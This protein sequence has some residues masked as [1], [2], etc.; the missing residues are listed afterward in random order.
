MESRVAFLAS[1]VF[2]KPFFW[3][4]NLSWTPSSFET[5]PWATRFGAGV[6]KD[7]VVGSAGAFST[8]EKTTQ[9]GK[10]SIKK[11]W[12]FFRVLIAGFS[13]LRQVAALRMEWKSEPWAQCYC[14]DS[15][16]Q[17]LSTWIFWNV[18]LLRHSV[19]ELQM[20]QWSLPQ[21]TIKPT[22]I[23]PTPKKIKPVL[24]TLGVSNRLQPV[25]WVEVEPCDS[26]FSFAQW[27]RVSDSSKAMISLVEQLMTRW[28]RVSQCKVGRS[29]YYESA[30][31]LDNLSRYWFFLYCQKWFWLIVYIFGCIPDKRC[32]VRSLCRKKWRFF[33]FSG[34]FVNRYVA[35]AF[36]LA[37]PK[38]QGPD[39]RNVQLR[40]SSRVMRLWHREIQ[41]TV[42]SCPPAA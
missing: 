6:A 40:S 1:V 18:Y 24:A 13:H 34:L 31:I 15:N 8:R 42:F 22:W 30:W 28:A 37:F 21:K 12:E 3:N 2:V 41:E 33:G 36:W 27:F 16:L 35:V 29:W 39:D 32:D 17:R 14:G 7:Q 10:T 26:H 20:F 25:A 5:T 19:N 9:A 11:L 38:G 23:P 4:N